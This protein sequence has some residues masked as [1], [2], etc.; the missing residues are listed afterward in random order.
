MEMKKDFQ[1]EFSLA[2]LAEMYMI[3]KG[4]AT[5]L[6]FLPFDLKEYDA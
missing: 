6:S 4:L 3:L 1:V 5:T 2:G